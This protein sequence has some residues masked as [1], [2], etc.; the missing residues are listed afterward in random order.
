MHLSI[1]G[2][3][4][5]DPPFSMHIPGLAWIA[6]DLLP[7]PSDMHIHS[8]HIPRIF[9]APN[10]IEQILS[11]IYLIGMM[12]KQLQ[13]IKLLR[14]KVDLPAKNKKSPALTI[15]TQLPCLDHLWILLLL[16]SRRGS[17]HDR[18]D[19]CL[20]LQDIKRLCDIIIRAVFK[21]EDLIHIVSIT[22]GISEN[23]R[24]C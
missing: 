20:Y 11:A 6:L 17:A 9:I 3:V 14:C 4:I 10:K 16:R 24:I 5:T 21:P 18:L 12:H 22:T 19:P 2:I 8:A 1:L 13:K 23:S 7:Q 15:K